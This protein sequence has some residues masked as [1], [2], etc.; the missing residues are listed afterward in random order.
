[1]THADTRSL[2][3]Q[4]AQRLYEIDPHGKGSLD[5]RP[6]SSVGYM[7]QQ[8]YQVLA[9]EVIRLMQYACL[10]GESHH[11]DGVCTSIDLDLPPKNWSLP[12]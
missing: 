7:T 11:S 3:D 6:W 4:L 1:M 10:N 9:A 2:E 8:R 5:I 12:Q